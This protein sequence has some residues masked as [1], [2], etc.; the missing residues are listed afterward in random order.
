MSHRQRRGAVR[1]VVRARERQVNDH[2]H[3]HARVADHRT[4]CPR[5]ADVQHAHVE[6]KL[7]ELC[8]SLR[9]P[10]RRIEPRPSIPRRGRLAD[11][12]GIDER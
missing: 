4:P 12:A 10:A 8:K 9:L 7:F 6:A 2:R 1:R 3:V 11:N 5:R